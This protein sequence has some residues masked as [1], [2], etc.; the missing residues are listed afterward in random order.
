MTFS[1]VV[2]APTYD[3][4]N[5]LGDIVRRIKKL[6]LGLIV[7][8]PQAWELIEAKREQSHRGWYYDLSR[9]RATFAAPCP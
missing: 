8:S 9:W 7:V 3:N 1:P 4:A 2:I 5:T 6:G